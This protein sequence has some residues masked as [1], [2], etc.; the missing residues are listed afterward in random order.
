MESQINQK[1]LHKIFATNARVDILILTCKRNIP[2]NRIIKSKVDIIQK[3]SMFFCEIIDILFEMIAFVIYCMDLKMMINDLWWWFFLKNSSN[4]SKNEKWIKL[5]QN[6]IAPSS[7]F[8]HFTFKKKSSHCSLTSRSQINMR[9]VILQCAQI[10][11]ILYMKLAITFC[12]QIGII[13][14]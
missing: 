4:I 9:L 5:K 10:I 11:N 3:N 6:N 7:K 12:T 14:Q 13:A 8:H 1:T 2:W